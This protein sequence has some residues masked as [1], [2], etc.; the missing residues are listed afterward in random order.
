MNRKTKTFLIAFLV[1]L[2]F[3]VVILMLPE[4]GAGPGLEMAG[5]SPAAEV[6]KA[7]I[8][9]PFDRVEVA[10]AG[11]RATLTRVDGE[12]W[13]LIPPE[14]ARVDRFKVRQILDGFRTGLT[15]VLSSP[16]SE[17]SLPSFGFDEDNRIRVTL[18]R[19]EEKAYDLEIGLVQKPEKGHGEGD[20]F[21]RIPD[22]DTAY[23]IIEKDLRKPFATGVKGL[24]DRRVFDWES[25]DVVGFRIDN[26]SAKE[27]ADRRIEL[28]SVEDPE[29]EKR[30]WSFKIPAGYEAGDMKSYAGSIASLYAQEYL[31]ELPQ[32]VDFNQG[33]CRI[34]V[35]VSDGRTESFAVSA[36]HEGSAYLQV[37][38]MS[39]YA[40][41]SKYNG[42]SI[43]KTVADFRDKTVF[44]MD[45]DEI[46][47]VTLS[48]QGT[49]LSFIRVKDRFTALV[50]GELPLGRTQVDSLLRDIETLKAKEI[51]PSAAVSSKVTGLSR[52]S[53]TIAVTGADGDSRTLRIGNETESGDF[54]GTVTGSGDVLVLAKWAL[55]KVRKSPTDMRNRKLFDFE[56]ERMASVAITHDDEKL[57]LVRIGTEGEGE[58]G[59]KATTPV[60][61]VDLDKDKVRTLVNTLAGLSAKELIP[62]KRAASVGLGGKPALQVDVRLD[63][64]SK[65]RLKVSVQKKGSDPYGI[66][67]TEADF[68]NS[69]FTLNQYQVKNFQKRLAELK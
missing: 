29:K 66:S 19:G 64:G 38:G 12:K 21:V 63:D 10:M 52:P 15:S 46:T 22:S 41:L 47:R 58:A 34:S 13:T 50:P 43:R 11:D 4:K 35:S 60:E 40:R 44:G 8:N 17:E 28:T 37:E 32:G 33:A 42:E 26:P 16:V 9:G 2:A 1:L 49:V 53:A 7:E 54:Y 24:R 30:I 59:W 67:P 27:A 23:R 3:V 68:R 61:A 57:T 55:S 56:A 45:R 18:F 6:D 36:T 14:G 39:G 51:L 25:K 48:D 20:T 65:H 5:W 31:D 69:V 62:A